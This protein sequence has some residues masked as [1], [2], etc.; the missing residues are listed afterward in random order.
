MIEGIIQF[1]MKNR[2]AVLLGTAILFLVGLFNATKLSIDAVP[3]ITNVQVSAVT[4]SPGLSPLEVEQ[5]ITYPIELEF[6]GMPKVREIRSIS[7]TGVSAVTIIFEDGTDIYFARQ[8]VNERL[9]QAEEL[10]PKGYGKPELSP[11]STGLGD[12]YEF[13]LSSEKHTNAELKT[14][15]K[16]E[17]ARQ[18]R[19]VKG[20]I[21]VNVQGGDEKQFQIKIDPR[22]LQTLNLTLSHI[23]EA[24]ESAN[25]N[26]GGGYISKGEEQIVIRG[27]SQFKNIEEIRSVAVR[28]SSDGI[29]ILLGQIATVEEGSALKFGVATQNGKG[30]VVALTAMMLMGENSLVVVDSVKQK[31]EE[32]RAKLPEGMVIQSFYDRSEFISRTLTT[33]FT[34]LVEAAVLVLIIL[35]FTLGSLKGAFAVA[36]AIPMS[37]LTATIFMNIF[38]VVGNL[39]SLGALDF[40][41]L[42]DG[43]IVML[44]SVLHGFI[45]Q[46]TALDLQKTKQDLNLL[47]EDIILR[48]CQKVARA[49]TFAVAIILL[50]YLPLMTLEGTEGRMFRPMAITVALALGAALLYSLTTF[51]ALLSFIYK[52]PNFK[53]PAYWEK[54]NHFYDGLLDRMMGMRNKALLGGVLVTIF[55]LGLGST[56]GSE[57]LP[58]IDEGELEIDLKRLPSTAL[59]HSKMLNSELEKYLLEI[60]EIT[61]AT[62]RMGR[63]DS[64]SEPIGTEEGTI[65]V[66]LKPRKEWTS[67]DDREELMS[68]II[69]KMVSNVPSTYFSI[70][71]PIENKVN[72]LLS[73][74]KADIVIKIYGD[75][76]NELKKIAENYAKTLKGVEG[77]ADVR[78]QRLLG[79][80]LLEIKADRAKMA[81]YGVSSE[82]ILT[83]VETLRVGYNVGKVY[84]GYKRFDLIIRLDANVSDMEVLENVPVMTS[85]GKT[86]PLG[87]VAKIELTEGPS[88]LYHENLK[89]RILVETNVRGRDMI[90]FVN[91]SIE[92]TEPIQASLAEGYSVDWGGQ[93]ENFTRAKQRLSIVVPVALMI[94]FGMLFI[95]FGNIYYAMGVFILVPF[96]AAG[97]VLSLVLR[98]L[99]FS[100]PAGV[101]F[102]AAAGIS[103]LNGV[104]FA[105]QLKLTLE[106][107]KD[108]A[109]AV[110]MS[111]IG[112]LRA[113]IT[114][115]LVAIIG[116]LPMAIATS[117]GA[118]VQKPLASVVIGGVL[119][120]TILALLL[121]PLIFQFLVSAAF[122]LEQ[123][124]ERKK[125]ELEDKFLVE[126]GF[127]QTSLESFVEPVED[128]PN[129]TTK[130]RKKK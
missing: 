21:D 81:R 90:G 45:L 86:V 121:L 130:K 51:P 93:F 10:I 24:L 43:S 88:A 12:I 71:Q 54:L 40:G 25:M 16:W 7:R 17:V 41:L 117:A 126:K 74:S 6:N 33:V 58:K 89:R 35:I 42:V 23:G 36:F 75:D 83:T 55:C 72:A 63:G 39:M 26:V 79:L 78:V 34:N 70:S 69:D 29:P 59:S 22:R 37:M 15:L 61:L 118:E 3:D 56:L 91:E 20:I 47:T 112:S 116:F 28:T 14:Y 5:F 31:V 76:L 97:G 44:E 62:A 52:E 27:E 48:S 110:R 114:T 46:R 82:E 30:E 109:K 120:A 92:A 106:K 65:M 111:A 102:I 128:E 87:Q 113:V 101:G 50:V 127:S 73:G 18:L 77:A 105:S 95:A 2:I 68:I 1:S 122:D 94:I 100:I 57:F 66:K 64:A 84:E 129:P 4:A 96:S 124:K 119:F 8:L 19:S 123:S 67:T 108:I 49:S 32:I 53:E 115:V 98:G 80:P 11:I 107:T 38:G 103:V 85:Q 60:P 13:T 125:Q 104:V 9:K 99:P